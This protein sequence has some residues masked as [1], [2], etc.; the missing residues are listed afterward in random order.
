MDASAG[1]A[2]RT[3]PVRFTGPA[4]EAAERI[5]RLA[6]ARSR[7][8]RAVIVEPDLGQASTWAAALP[9]RAQVVLQ[10]GA[11]S[12]AHRGWVAAAGRGELLDVLPQLGTDG[13]MAQGVDRLR[14]LTDRG[15]VR[16]L[17]TEAT[18]GAGRMD[19]FLH[20]G[21]DGRR[22][23]ILREGAPPSSS[24][25]RDERL[26][27]LED[28]F[29]ADHLDALARELPACSPPVE[30]I[31]DATAGTPDGSG[32]SLRPYQ[33][34][35]IDAW[36]ASD[37]AGIIVMATG[38][39]KTFTAIRA[40]DTL[41]THV[42]RGL[43]VVVMVP[44]VHLADQWA[45]ELEADGRRPVVCH[46]STD[47]WIG[48]AST[49]VDLLRAGHRPRVTLVTTYASA[50]L[51][52]FR[53]VMDRVPSDDRLV[54]LDE[55]HHFSERPADLPRARYRLGL[56]ATPELRSDDAD[57]RGLT[58]YFGAVVARYDL[59]DAIA[60]GVLCPYDYEPH[61]VPL[62][63][64]ELDAFQAIT[65]QLMELSS[66][67]PSRRD[68]GAIRELLEQRGQTLDR[69]RG[70][71]EVLRELLDRTMPDR[72]I[73]YCSG[74]PQLE[75]VTAL[76]WELGISAHQLTA[77]ESAGRRRELLGRFAEGSIPVLTAIR[78][79]DE[80]VDV[81]GAREAYLLRSSANP[82]QSVQR[83]G[84][85]LR[86]SP[87]KDRATIHDL[88]TIGADRQLAQLERDRVRRFAA[89]ADNRDEAIRR[90]DSFW[91]DGT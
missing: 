73:V 9:D 21:D 83:R 88:V 68:H 49:E 15:Q 25:A 55:A 65:A 1:P 5:H 30:Q 77:Q 38:A 34:Q 16:W 2:A 27:I 13:P 89:E 74:R 60:D 46:T 50:Q 85:L 7:L 61:A 57:D 37:G 87:G 44:Q 81:P 84:R 48:T 86:T 63:S 90:S 82:T 39:G 32:P 12:S 41:Q 28:P 22:I 56:T 47:T 24:T 36:L 58:G 54:I 45:E 23:G 67:H 80:G 64:E 69:A 20:E 8:T 62:S 66:E 59:G 91:E 75:A 52:A 3:L 29:D 79:L 78:C 19:L 70:K 4:H 11:S 72:T 51:P 26:W 18:S 14:S 71:L 42:S 76:C 35:A 6:A 40:A 10:L 43:L 53:E 33:E 17:V 31:D